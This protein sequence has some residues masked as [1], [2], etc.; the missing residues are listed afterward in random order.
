MR[1]LKLSHDEIDLITASLNHIY[2]NK[3]KLLGTESL[4]LSGSEKSATS[5]MATKIMNLAHEIEEGAKDV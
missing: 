2:A 4:I 5:I 3:Q 1:T